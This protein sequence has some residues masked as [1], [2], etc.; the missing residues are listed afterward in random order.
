MRPDETMT[1]LSA[2][3]DSSSHGDGRLAATLLTAYGALVLLQ[4]LLPYPG[5]SGAS[6]EDLLLTTLH[7]AVALGVAI[8]LWRRTKWAWWSA[9]ALAAPGLF[10][11]LPVAMGLL[12][13]AGRAPFRSP[14][15]LGFHVAS[16][17]TLVLL[18][19]VLLVRRR[20][21]GV[22]EGPP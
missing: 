5:A 10:F 14:V 19:A 7:M 13:G 21:F 8:G 11:L 16:L 12:L 15:E 9:L 2:G 20:A 6:R 18:V 3:T 4:A 22:G 1:P 17:I